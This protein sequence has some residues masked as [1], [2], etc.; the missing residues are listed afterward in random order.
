MGRR[1]PPTWSSGGLDAIGVRAVK[2][3]MRFAHKPPPAHTAAPA[4]TA[5]EQLSY[6]G[7]PV[8]N[9]NMKR[10]VSIPAKPRGQTA[11]PDL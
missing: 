4:E 11:K 9:A 6:R 7:A 10:P 3:P 2:P 8:W 1:T 5:I